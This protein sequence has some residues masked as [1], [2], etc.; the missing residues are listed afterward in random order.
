MLACGLDWPMRKLG[1]FSIGIFSIVATVVMH[2]IHNIMNKFLYSTFGS[3]CRY[4][5]REIIVVYCG[6][7]D[8][9]NDA[10]YQ[11]ICNQP[12]KRYLYLK[13]LFF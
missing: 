2:T 7:F 5:H 6:I 11:K 4:I 1:K 8:L 13:I 9:H 12:N 10:L 3:I